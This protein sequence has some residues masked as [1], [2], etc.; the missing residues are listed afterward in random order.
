MDTTPTAPARLIAIGDVHGM[1]ALLERLLDQI[2]PT[3]EDQ[4]VFMGDYIDRGDH[5]REAID[6]LIRLKQELPDTVFLRGN[7]DQ[8]LIDALIEQGV[9]DGRRL[10]DMSPLFRE[11]GPASDLEKF[12]SIGRETMASYGITDLADLPR[13]HI[14]FL[15]ST[16]L[17]WQQDMFIFVHAGIAPALPMAEQDP[18]TLLWERNAPPGQGGQVH[19]VG[20]QP[21]DGEPA[22]EPGRINVDTGAVYGHALTACEVRT[23]QV[24]QVR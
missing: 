17:W 20:H 12:L 9:A 8:M 6:R 16:R 18:Y 13:R 5:C 7:H 22:F 24:W 3:A 21:T 14:D 2:S 1:E 23:K 15:Q 4:L 10:R 19:I 11:K